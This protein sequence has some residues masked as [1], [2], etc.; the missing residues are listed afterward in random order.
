MLAWGKNFMPF[1]NLF[2]DYFPGYNKFRAVT[3]T[4]VIAEFCIPLLGIL[5][6]RDILDGTSF[7]ERCLEGHQDS[8]WD[9]R[10]HYPVVSAHCRVWPGPFYPL[11][12]H[13][14]T[15]RHGS[16]AALADDRKMLLRG[17][18]L[19][20]FFLI[21]LGAATTHRLLLQ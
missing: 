7:P 12:N 21:L 14:Q 5:A 6:V 16:P 10:G 13:R 9:N 20:S 4:L 18:S 8:F 1:T 11:Q 2:L 17:D 19:R 3:M 15:C